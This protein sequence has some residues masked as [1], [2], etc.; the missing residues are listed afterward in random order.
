MFFKS[1][2]VKP[3]QEMA[4]FFRANPFNIGFRN[5][6]TA[7]ANPG[8]YPCPLVAGPL[9]GYW[10]GVMSGVITAEEM[11]QVTNEFNKEM[12][13]IPRRDNTEGLRALVLERL[14]LR[15]YGRAREDQ[16]KR[17]EEQ[18]QRREYKEYIKRVEERKRK[19]EAREEAFRKK[20]A[21]ELRLG[22]STADEDLEEGEVEEAQEAP[23]P[24][25]KRPRLASASWRVH[26]SRARVI[27]DDGS[28]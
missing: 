5:P 13:F 7:N 27:K 15:R 21:K 10:S 26:K 16:R 1:A 22:A 9:D 6:E 11:K 17:A 25:A 23:T 14:W 28:D 18:K 12:G 2:P 20:R 8:D 19:K 4:R 3:A 24:L